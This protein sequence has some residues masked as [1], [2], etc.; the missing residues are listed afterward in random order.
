MSPGWRPVPPDQPGRQTD[1]NLTDDGVLTD[2]AILAPH[3]ACVEKVWRHAASLVDDPEGI[4]LMLCFHALRERE[5]MGHCGQCTRPW[6]CVPWQVA[7][8]ARILQTNAPVRRRRQSISWF[9]NS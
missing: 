1:P 4:E 5:P 8:L 2:E 3:Y 7:T 9:K 6:P